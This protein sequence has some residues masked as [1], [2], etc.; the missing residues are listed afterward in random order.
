M[1]EQNNSLQEALKDTGNQIS[2][3]V[4]SFIELGVLV[5][6]FQASDTS[7]QS[8]SY[9]LNQT[10]EQL[11]KLS[12]MHTEELQK[13]PIPLDVLQYIEDGRNPNVYTR[14][15]VESTR[16]SNQ[17]LRGKIQAFKQLRDT[18]GAKIG[19][20]FPELKEEIEGIYRRTD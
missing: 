8:L 7:A 15:F 9:R 10:I 4:E 18:L 11:L 5:H 6:D 13:L 16:K 19:D 2:L 3:V 20:E 12:T 1:T 14:E 17:H